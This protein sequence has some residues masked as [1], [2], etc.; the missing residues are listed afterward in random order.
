MKIL[1]FPCIC[2][3]ES[4]KKMPSTFLLSEVNPQNT[5]EKYCLKK[6]R[7]EIIPKNTTKIEEL[8]IA[9]EKPNIISFLDDSKQLKKCHISMINFKGKN[10]YPRET[11]KYKCFWDKEII[12]ENIAY[13]GCPIRYVPDRAIKGYFSEIS[14]DTY[15]I[16]EDITEERCREL[17]ERKD[18]RISLEKNGYYETDGVFCSFN[19]MLAWI[20]SPENMNNSAYKNSEPLIY[21]IYS[22]L[23]PSSKPI[24]LVSA[25]DWR[26]LEAFGGHLSIEKYRDSF[27]KISYENIGKISCRSVGYLFENNVKL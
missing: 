19:C 25:P 27:N 23:F 8:E 1:I 6:P 12:P 13:L 17:E 2:L 22:E 11:R 18:S 21:K 16:S 4:Q 10:I 9:K 15:I 3:S 24:K 20:K 26:T 14:K 7:P 5:I